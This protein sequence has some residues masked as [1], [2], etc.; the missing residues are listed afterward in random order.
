[1]RPPAASQRRSRCASALRVRLAARPSPRADTT[2]QGLLRKAA[3]YEGTAPPQRRLRPGLARLAQAQ[4]HAYLRA[5]TSV[6]KKPRKR[7]VHDLRVV[8]R[9]ILALRDLVRSIDPG[10]NDAKLDEQLRRPFKACGKLRDLQVVRDR[11]RALR[12]QYPEVEPL[13]AELKRRQQRARTRLLQ[14]L[15]REQPR[16]VC[17]KLGVLCAALGVATADRA[18]R[19]R[20]AR[21]IKQELKRALLKVMTARENARAFDAESIHQARR[22]FKTYRY[23]VELAASLGLP[24][25]T[26]DVESIRRFQTALGEITDR[27]TLLQAI[28]AYAR[29]HTR[30]GRHL[31]RFRARIEKEHGTFI[32]LYLPESQRFFVGRSGVDA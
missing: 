24:L 5:S 22:V 13:L 17:R 26:F 1:M 14:S 4:S 18:G 21:S 2:M 9:T 30:K 28:D 11:V 23:M 29:K 20:A 27:A 6:Q 19:E 16:R 25:R 31:S 15:S 8:T 3:V 12:T 32:E 7:L 10:A